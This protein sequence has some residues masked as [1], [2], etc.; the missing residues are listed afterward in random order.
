MKLKKAVILTVGTVLIGT[1]A[2]S[3]GL[4]KE[5]ETPQNTALTAAYYEVRN[6]STQYENGAFGNLLWEQVFTDPVL[7]DLINRALVNNSNLNDARTNVEIAQTQLKGAKLANL[8]SVSLS[9]QGALGKIG[10]ASPYGDWSKTYTIPAATVS[11]EAD[12]FG[13]NLNNKRSSEI[14]VTRAEDYV[15]AVRSQLI[16]GVANCYYSIAAI[17]AQLRLS[18][19]TALLWQKSVETMKAL[20]EGSNVTEAAVVQSDANY[21]SVLASITQLEVTRRQLDNTMSLLLNTMPQHFEVSAD[22]TL[23][24]PNVI[25]QG[26]PMQYL[27]MRPDVHAAEMGMAQAYYT[28]NLARAA[29]YP[30][31][32]ITAN[33]GYTNSLGSMVVNP[34]KWF[35]NLAGSLV[36]PIFTRGQNKARLEAAKLQQKLALS[37]F[38]SAVLAAAGEVSDYLTIYEKAGERKVHLDAQV[39]DLEKA[40]EY[41]NDLLVYSN[42]TYLEVLTAQQSLLSAQTNRISTDLTRIQAV[43]NLYQAMGGGR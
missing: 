43:I 31:L 14:A 22:A 6:D 10:M 24:V 5:Y 17:E 35:L 2:T 11:W 21:R 16:A 27:A 33:G 4:Y 19:S 29:F 38:E 39:A 8:P 3:C 13:K 9:G 20:K 36:A 18:R 7:A 37:A 1:A 26:V 15:Q 40:V 32:T 30:A 25:V 34:G 41:T 28:T 42:G 12:I 23:T